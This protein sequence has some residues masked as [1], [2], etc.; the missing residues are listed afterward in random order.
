MWIG[1]PLRKKIKQKCIFV[2]TIFNFVVYFHQ[3]PPAADLP[4]A[5]IL[6]WA[7][8]DLLLRHFFSDSMK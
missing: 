6:K 8:A 1:Y 4:R 7:K 2:G 5:L 3:D